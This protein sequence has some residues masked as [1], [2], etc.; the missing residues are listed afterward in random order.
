MLLAQLEAFVEAARRGSISAAA[1]GLFVTQP[2]LTARIKSLERELGTSLLV[3]TGRGVR[4]SDTGRAFMPY[5]LRALD[6]A[7]AGRQRVAELARGEV[8][9]LALAAAPAVSTYV[10]PTILKRFRIAHPNVELAVRTGHSE[11]LL[12]LVL[13]DE[14]ELGLVRDLRHP[15]IEATPLYEDEL[16]FVTNPEHAAAAEGSIRADDL[17]REQLILFDRTSSY[18][19]LTNAYFREAGVVPRNVMELDN[20]DAAKKMVEHGLGFALLPHTAIAGELE[21]GSLRP[22]AMVD[23]PTVRRRIV[24]IRR[25]DAGPPTGVSAAFLTSLKEMRPDLQRAASL[26]SGSTA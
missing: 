13:A 17:S 16:V 15:L 5:A 4:L 7:A 19:E 26:P 24:A 18:H 14:V 2:A 21:A 11:E 23:A 25:Q 3:R 1:E 10:L 20:I 12:E 22:V 8:G 6:A 9:E